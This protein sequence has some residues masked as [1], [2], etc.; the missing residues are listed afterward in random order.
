MGLI[1]PSM[2]SMAMG[3]ALEHIERDRKRVFPPA[4]PDPVAEP[5]PEPSY[6]WER[7]LPPVTC[8]VPFAR[9][10]PAFDPRQWTAPD[11]ADTIEFAAI[12]NA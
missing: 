12:S 1:I 7:E 4:I 6:W 11:K 5:R 8:V 2:R 10:W 9:T 3:A